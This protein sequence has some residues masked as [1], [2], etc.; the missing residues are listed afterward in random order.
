MG[1]E[2]LDNKLAYA[3]SVKKRYQAGELVT[4]EE[5]STAAAIFVIKPENFRK[6]YPVITLQTEQNSHSAT[7]IQAA[8]GGAASEYGMTSGTSGVTG[9]LALMR[10]KNRD[11]HLAS[12]RNVRGLIERSED[13]GFSYKEENDGTVTFTFANANGVGVKAQSS[14]YRLD[15]KALAYLREHAPVTPESV[16]GRQSSQKMVIA[17]AD[18]DPTEQPTGSAMTAALAQGRSTTRTI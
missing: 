14:G 4:D 12:R 7:F 6:M 16:Q 13:M 3:S 11:G 18:V 1:N 9:R 17:S 15:E 8:F 5:I 10:E 2:P